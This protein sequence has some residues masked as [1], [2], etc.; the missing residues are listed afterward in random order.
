M[1]VS[2]GGGGRVSSAVSSWVVALCC[3]RVDVC[4][5]LR[6]CNDDEVEVKNLFAVFAPDFS[7]PSH[8]ASSTTLSALFSATKYEYLELVQIYGAEYELQQTNVHKP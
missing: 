3:C 1:V 5:V 8:A 7:T 2:M 6:G 4:S